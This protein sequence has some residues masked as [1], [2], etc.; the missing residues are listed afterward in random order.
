[1]GPPPGPPPPP[2]HPHPHPHPHPHTRAR[3]RH[4]LGTA[5]VLAVAVGTVLAVAPADASGP[6]P[7]G[8]HA[9]PGAEAPDPARAALPLGCDGLPVK[10][11]QTFTADLTGDGDVATV[12]AAHC[13]SPVGTPPDG[14]YLLKDGPGGRPRVADVLIGS[15]ERLTVRSVDF[16]AD[17]VITA[18]VDGYSSINVPRCCPDLHESLVWTPNGHGYRRSV[19]LTGI[20][21]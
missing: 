11:T 5:A 16:R 10:V 12:A 3:A 4:W 6:V 18:A 7:N 2:A 1:V 13:L 8:P 15:S 14:L 9:V 21:A 17:G 19:V 20:Q